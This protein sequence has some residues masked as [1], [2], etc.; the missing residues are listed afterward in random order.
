MTEPYTSSSG[1]KS[2]CN[3]PRR[4]K[5]FCGCSTQVRRAAEHADLPDLHRHARHAAGDESPRRLSWPED[6]RGAELPDR[7][8]H[9][10]GSQELLLSRPAQGLS[11]QPVRSAVQPRRLAR[12]QRSQGTHRAEE[13]RHHPRPPGRRRRQEH[14]R[15]SGRRG[16]Q[17]HRSEPRR[18]A[19]VGNRQPARHAFAGRSQGLSH[20]AQAAARPIWASPTATCRKA[21]CGSTP[22]STCTSTRPRANASPRRSS[23][24]R[25]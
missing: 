3:L 16:R 22:T 7:P 9:Q 11:D 25:T 20:R 10:V 6:G 2:T 15:R 14:A 1:W 5:L 18:H 23:K 24:S 12:D 8:V 4:R 13:D 21:A 19:A 17:P